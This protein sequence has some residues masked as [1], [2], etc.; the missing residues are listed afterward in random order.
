MATPSS[1]TRPVSWTVWSQVAAQYP[2]TIHRAAFAPSKRP[3]APLFSVAPAASAKSLR[4]IAVLTARLMAESLPRV[5]I[6][7]T[8]SGHIKQVAQPTCAALMSMAATPPSLSIA[9]ILTAAL[10]TIATFPPTTIVR[11]FTGGVTVRG[12]RQSYIQDVSGTA[13]R[14]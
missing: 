1:T 11:L 12:D 4:Y 14:G 3:M 13:L 2:A 8:L 10:R 5:R 7:G 9:A 6:V